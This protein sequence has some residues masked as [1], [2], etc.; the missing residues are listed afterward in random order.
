MRFYIILGVVLLWVAA[1][2]AKAKEIRLLDGHLSLATQ[3]DVSPSS[4]APTQSERFSVL[5]DLT[6]SDGSFSVLVTY[7]KHSLD[8]PPSV[9]DI[10]RGK[11]SSYSSLNEKARHFH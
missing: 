7:G 1:E 3:V 6:S 5:S 9:A 8:T 2:V 4:C 11:V 10:L